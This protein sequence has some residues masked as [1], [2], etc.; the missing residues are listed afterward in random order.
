MPS[1]ILKEWIFL[2]PTNDFQCCLHA[3]K[4][5]FFRFHIFPILRNHIKSSDK[6][7]I[8]TRL[9]IE[10]G[11]GQKAHYGKRMWT[12]VYEYVYNA[13]RAIFFLM[14]GKTTQILILT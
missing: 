9:K 1:D 2:L 13:Y 8:F 12:G 3:Q 6:F 11:G 5:Y 4:N 14:V 7:A 10:G